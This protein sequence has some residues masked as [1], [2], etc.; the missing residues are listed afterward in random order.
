MKKD[1][2]TLEPAHKMGYFVAT[3]HEI[4]IEVTFKQYDFKRTQEVM[5]LDGENYNSTEQ[6]M[7]APMALHEMEVWLHKKHFD[8]VIAPIEDKRLEMGRAIRR[9][10]IQKGM[11]EQDLS[12][13]AGLTI[14][15]VISV[16]QGRYA[17]RL[18]VLNRIAFV[19]GA[20]IEMKLL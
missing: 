8:E 9:L 6:A 19:L 1:R 14:G 3:D 16:E 20:K 13:A 17:Y 5:L 12:E 4:G 7:A 18:D 11:T 2:F 10:R 15:N